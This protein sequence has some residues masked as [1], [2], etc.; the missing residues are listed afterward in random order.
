M[1]KD[2]GTLVHLAAGGVS[3]SFRLERILKEV[4]VISPFSWSIRY[5]VEGCQRLCK[6]LSG[7]MT[8]F[9]PATDSPH[10]YLLGFEYEGFTYQANW[11]RRTPAFHLKRATVPNRQS[12]FL[13]IN[14]IMSMKNIKK[15][16]ILLSKEQKGEP[17]FDEASLRSCFANF[18]M[19]NWR[20]FNY[21]WRTWLKCS[22]RWGNSDSYDCKGAV[23]AHLHGL[24]LK[25]RMIR[26]WWFWNNLTYFNS[27]LIENPS[28]SY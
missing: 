13:N 5:S 9:I 2:D 4:H 28:K 16:L 14:P 25:R 12:Q 18:Q 8:S 11:R 22:P 24:L 1:K 26:K 10:R 21:A 19:K 27:P 15:S 23:R 7:A 20:S 6:E 17:R 3:T